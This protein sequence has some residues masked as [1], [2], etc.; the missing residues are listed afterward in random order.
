MIQTTKNTSTTSLPKT[1]QIKKLGKVCTLIKGKKPKIFVKKSNIPYL[2]AKV[3][4]KTAIP[5]FASEKCTSSILVKEDDIVIIMDGS[6]SGEMFTGLKGALA[7]TMGIVKYSK[8]LLSAK[9]L[10]F[11]LITHRENFTK[12]RTGAAIPHLNKEE[13]QE[14]KIPLPPLPEQIR[15]VKILDKTFEK[16]EI[17][18]KNAEKNLMNA[19]ELF[20]SYLQDIFED[21]GDDWEKKELGEVCSLHQ[22]IAIN[23]KTRHALVEKSEL[24]LLRI[25]DLRNNTAEQYID[26]NNYPINALVNK[27]DIIYTRT[28]NSLGMV[29]RG[30]KGVLH[31][32]SFKIVPNSMLSRDF[33]YIW[34][35]NPTFKSKIFSL[36]SKAAQPDITHKIF[37]V[38]KIYIPPLEIQDIIVK[39]LNSLS[40]QT[41]KLEKIYQ[42]KLDDLE[43][44]K[45]SV[46]KKAFEG[47]L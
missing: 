33:L 18:K 47:K 7:S 5:E 41:K 1:W 3:I 45:K 22:G 15:I 21:S 23:A 38:Q 27:K 9:Y 37:K 19:K 36:A 31:N 6:N 44:L 46:L 8:D 11:F 25:K 40:E 12:S 34:L 17:A 24:P 35:Q 13:F 30:R 32:N 29:F 26:P 20:E 39:K 43:E 2:T 4:R 42:Q 16:L 10:L 14:L 28:G